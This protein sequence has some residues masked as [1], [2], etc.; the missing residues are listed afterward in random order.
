MAIEY[1]VIIPTHNRKA[2]LAEALDALASQENAPS[3][4]VIVVDDG[5][6]D[7]TTDM[8]LGRTGSVRLLPQPGSGPATARNAGARAASGRWLAFLGDDTIPS[9]T[10]LAAHAKARE[11]LPDADKLAAVGYTRWH[12][13]IRVTPFLRYINEQGLQFGYGMIRDPKDV[14]FNFF[15]ASNLSI[16]RELFLSHLFEGNFRAAAW[17]D[18]E[19][20]YRLKKKGMRLIYEPSAIVEHDHPT[21][22]RSF[23][24][25]QRMVGRSAVVFYR[26]HPELGS[27]LGLSPGGPPPF[28]ARSHVLAMEIAIRLLERTT[29]E[30][31][32]WWNEVMRVHYLKGLHEGWRAESSNSCT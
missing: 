18:I 24:K 6:T 23:A 11:G 12:H 26:L 32:D 21:S 27:F 30:R 7:G 14:P 22:V 28:P 20:G 31:P 3:F 15:Y 17:E 29:V 13:R 8:V 19:V 5:S 1:S 10:W 9:P 25:R 2:L 4:E 16:S